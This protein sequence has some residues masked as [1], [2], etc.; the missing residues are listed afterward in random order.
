MVTLARCG[1]DCFTMAPDVAERLFED[2]L[3]QEAV[4]TFEAAVMAT[5]EAATPE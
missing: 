5:A 4:R 2:E 1:V 3:T